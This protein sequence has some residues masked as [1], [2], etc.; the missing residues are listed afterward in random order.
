MKGAIASEHTLASNIGAAILS[1]GGNAVDACI[2]AALAVGTL[3]PYHSCV[4]GGGFAIVRT[5]DGVKS[6][7]FRVTAPVRPK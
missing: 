4:G 7:D 5:P 3:N 6:L 1:A 2:A